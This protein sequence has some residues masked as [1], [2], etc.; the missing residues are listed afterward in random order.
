MRRVLSLVYLLLA[1]SV[2]SSIF[3]HLEKPSNFLEDAEMSMYIT[4][5][6]QKVQRFIN[7]SPNQDILFFMYTEEIEGAVP[8][9]IYIQKSWSHKITADFFSPDGTAEL[10]IRKYEK[11]PIYIPP[12]S[13]VDIVVKSESQVTL[14]C[15]MTKLDN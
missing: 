7:N 12:Q 11:I 4:L 10:N 2:S 8:T 3:H 9:V 14:F 6:P 5:E 13:Y 1:A 15:S